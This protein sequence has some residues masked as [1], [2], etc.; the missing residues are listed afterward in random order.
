MSEQIKSMFAGLASRYD[1][2]NT[3]LSLGIHKLWRRKVVRLSDA[4]A[5]M[6]IL[7]CATGTGD[8]ALEFKKAVGQSGAVIGTDFC[9]EMLDFAPA[10]AQQQGLE[11]QFELADAMNLQYADN[12]YDIASIS[13]GIRN[14]DSPSQ[15]LKEMARVVRP[16]GRVMILEFGQPE[17]MFRYLYSLYR[18]VFMPMLGWIVTG[19]NKDAYNYLLDTTAVF[20][21]G[22]KFIEMMETSGAFTELRYVPFT[23]GIAY[24][25]IGKVK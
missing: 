3:V 1:R 22:K 16:G 5:G 11:V 25:Y 14:V 24:L 4:K 13:F 15:C 12:T 23:F 9:A 19:K 17:G 10:K 18:A 8:L 7:D 6:S 20:P 21:S 2:T